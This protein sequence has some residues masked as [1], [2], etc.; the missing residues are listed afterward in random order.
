M[1]LKFTTAWC[2]LKAGEAPDN[3]TFIISEYASF[4]WDDACQACGQYSFQLLAPVSHDV[5]EEVEEGL[6]IH[7]VALFAHGGF[8]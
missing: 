8:A 7:R 3:V 2:P 5:I 1:Q 4:A 6:G